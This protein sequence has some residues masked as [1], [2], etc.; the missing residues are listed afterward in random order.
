LRILTPLFVSQSGALRDGCKQSFCHKVMFPSLLEN[1]D[2][3]ICFS[4]R[5]FEGWLQAILL[6]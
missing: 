5:S 2:S 3:P 6:L 1:F 4:K